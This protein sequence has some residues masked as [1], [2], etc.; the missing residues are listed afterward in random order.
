M[1]RRAYLAIVVP[2]LI[3][4]LAGVPLLAVGIVKDMSNAERAYAVAVTG[5]RAIPGCENFEGGKPGAPWTYSGTGQIIVTD[6][7][8]N[9]NDG[10]YLLMHNPTGQSTNNAQFPLDYSAQANVPLG[11]GYEFK[12]V[13]SF[14]YNN[15]GDETGST[16][17]LWA[18]TVARTMVRLHDLCNT[19]GRWT[20]VTL[21]LASDLG[22]GVFQNPGVPVTVR[23]TQCDNQAWPSDGILIDNVCVGLD[24]NDNGEFD[25]DEIAAD[26]SLDCDQNGV[27][28]AAQ[29]A[30]DCNNNGEQDFCEDHY[31]CQTDSDG[32]EVRDFC[33]QN[34]GF[35]DNG[36]YWPVINHWVITTRLGDM[37]D[38]GGAAQ[39][40]DLK[41]YADAA[42]CTRFEKNETFNVEIWVTSLRHPVT[43]LS[44]GIICG[45]ID[46]SVCGDC[47]LQINEP[48]VHGGLLNEITTG[49]LNGCNMYDFGGCVA[50]F[51][52]GRGT[53]VDYWDWEWILIGRFTVTT[54]AYACPMDQMPAGLV[55]VTG[56]QWSL[57][58]VGNVNGAQINL[59][60][61][62][63]STNCRAFMYDV[64]GNGFI[65]FQDLLCSVPECSGTK[66][67]DAWLTCDPDPAY[68]AAFDWD[69]DGC[70]GPGD[71]GYWGT[72]F[73]KWCDDPSIVI[74]PVWPCDGTLSAPL[75]PPA[76]DEFI[77]SL[78]LPLPP[79]DWRD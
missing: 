78:G 6:T 27:L 12:V 7:P 66:F 55:S 30:E 32:D 63:I 35:D 74:P 47:E 69:C 40:Q 48:L 18:G 59:P 9:G 5:P 26:P 25:E 3:G 39:F 56:A 77:Q 19:D 16:D 4:V 60:S 23:F 53:F 21:D 33:D 8:I 57:Y 79:A 24:I 29:V 50:G 49:E 10:K 41:A 52:A 68:C 46:L 65:D 58:G 45:N 70:V 36:S 13:L 28:D 62:G 1:K 37:Q 2:V 14:D 15:V 64:D 61:V 75:V 34:P 51:E 72:G 11:A 38:L 43:G 44:P 73:E 42:N 22:V 20:T 71:L 54:P 17:G 31:L 67:V 76:S